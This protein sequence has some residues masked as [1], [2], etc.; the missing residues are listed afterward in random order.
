MNISFNKN[1]LCKNDSLSISQSI[2]IT[3][4]VQLLK[5][6]LTKFTHIKFKRSKFYCFIPIILAAVVHYGL[7]IGSIKL[8]VVTLVPIDKRNIA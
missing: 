5:D 4:C 3:I 8:A 2:T 7:V 6:F 1:I